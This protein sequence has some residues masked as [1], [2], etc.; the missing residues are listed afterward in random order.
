[1][2]TATLPV[3]LAQALSCAK[4]TPFTNSDWDCWAGASGQAHT[5]QFHADHA[6]KLAELLGISHIPAEH[7]TVVLD[8]TGL[9]WNISSPVNMYAWQVQVQLVTG[10]S[11]VPTQNE[12][13]QVDHVPP[14]SAWED[15][16]VNV[17]AE[18]RAM[19]MACPP[20]ARK[21]VLQG[22]LNSA[23]DAAPKHT[24]LPPHTIWV[25]QNELSQWE[26]RQRT[27]TGARGVV[28][29]SASY[30][31][32]LDWL[33]DKHDARIIHRPPTTDEWPERG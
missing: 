27:P 10:V 24:P 15:Q 20:S 26:V 3:V 5:V 1:M 8:D 28:Y 14:A 19:I 17:P 21:W 32:A 25:F 30:N 18:H 7:I 2:S 33:Q 31:A 16:L 29:V 22:Y 9:T 6:A 23:D 13:W 12:Y 4:L 11:D